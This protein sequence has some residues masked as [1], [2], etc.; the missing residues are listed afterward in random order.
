MTRSLSADGLRAVRL[1]AQLLA[2]RPADDTLAVVTRLGGLQAQSGSAAR[3]GIRVRTSGLTAD[4]VNRATAE[5][6]TVVRTWAMRGTLHMVPAVDVRWMVELLGPVFIKR[7]QRRR[8]QLGLDDR[9]CQRGL[10][11]IEA[12]LTGESP[13]T[14]ARLVERIAEH[15]VL[16]DPRSQAPAHLVA[17]AAMR[18]LICRGPDVEHDE[19][20]YVLLDEWVRTPA[21]RDRDEA[22]VEL[23]RRYLIGHAP[24]TAADF[25]TWSGLPAADV[26]TAFGL[27][28]HELSEV[29]VA[30]VRMVALTEAQLAVPVV[31]PAR[32]LGHF[33]AYLLGYR[34]RDLILESRYRK[35]IQ[36]GGGMIQPAVL[37]G[38][39]VVG[40]WRLGRTAKRAQL[41]VEPFATLSRSVRDALR[42]EAGDIGRF[43]GSDIAFEVSPA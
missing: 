4:D 29:Q 31:S 25:A 19:P 27:L 15:G 18:G 1:R 34:C 28:E 26:S 39:L 14:R 23:A 13:L 12:V 16:I 9:T 30:G 42:A 38:G 10:D 36:A 21:G 3:L 17:Y 22:L 6:P 2:G 8:E 37:A 5:K 20:T 32:L 41:V 7:G 11:A 43:L 24:A 40:T 33:D 35:R